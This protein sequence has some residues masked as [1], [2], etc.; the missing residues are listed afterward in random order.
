MH[1]NLFAGTVVQFLLILLADPPQAAS[2]A[3]FAA[4]WDRRADVG[5]AYCIR[6]RR[7]TCGAQ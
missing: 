1:Y 6:D 2:A 7:N 5:E 4:V 3:S